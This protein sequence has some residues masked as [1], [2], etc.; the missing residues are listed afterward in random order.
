MRPKKPTSFTAFASDMMI[1]E[2]NKEKIA[3]I[4]NKLSLSYDESYFFNEALHIGLEDI[5]TFVLKEDCH[6]LYLLDKKG[7]IHSYDIYRKRVQKE[8]FSVQY[9]ENNS[10]IDMALSSNVLYILDQKK[11]RAF[12]LITWQF[13]WE[14]NILDALSIGVDEKGYIYIATTSSNN[15]LK[16]DTGGT[17]ID[18]LIINGVDN[19]VSITTHRTADDKSKLVVLDASKVTIYDERQL[20]EVAIPHKLTDLSSI[21]INSKDT[22]YI[23]SSIADEDGTL[24]WDTKDAESIKNQ[25][26]TYNQAIKKIVF[27]ARDTLFVL[28]KQGIISLVS[29]Q[30]VYENSGE[31]SYVFDSTFEGCSWHKMRVDYDISDQMDSVV[32]SIGAFEHLSS[33][34]DVENLPTLSLSF[35]NKKDIYLQEMIGRYLVV[36]I[37]L[38]SNPQGE[39][40]PLFEKIKV[41][42]PKE[43]YL[44]YLPGIYQEDARSKELLEQYLSVFQTILEGIEEKI[45]NSH[46]LIDPQTTPNGEFLNWLSL[47]LGLNREK[48]WSDEKW[49]ELL[50]K[51]MYFFKRRGTRK[52]LSELIALY[53]QITKEE[54]KPI[55]I[56]PFQTQCKENEQTW[57]LGSYTFCVI[58]KPKVLNSEEELNTVKRIVKLWKPAHT[59]GKVV[60]LKEKMVL[61][62][63]LYLGINTALKKEPFVL[64]EAALSI[65]TTLADIEENAQIQSHARLGIDTQIKY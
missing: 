18:T 56:E 34:L 11:L 54:D 64:G 20:K 39:I 25:L 2:N 58:F 55:I 13:L 59:E 26:S 33:T 31:I 47:W 50:S 29:T 7:A 30:K 41:F 42:F 3:L 6:M 45:E 48:N 35:E 52:G 62:D 12:S 57:N 5:E 9:E 65:D 14:S 63:M 21:A 15:V 8:I 27:D 4:D 10:F 40:S 24:W 16:F 1:S 32:I 19:P 23:G 17:C 38:Q 60:V 28:D 61:G 46:L 22:I 53:T 43:T 49:R 44:Q 37:T 36:K 51:A